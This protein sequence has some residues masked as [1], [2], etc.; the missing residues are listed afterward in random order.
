MVVHSVL[1]LVYLGL[2]DVK[3]FVIGAAS[4]LLP[5]VPG[6]EREQMAESANVG[7]PGKNEAGTDEGRQAVETGMDEVAQP[8]A[9]EDERAGR[10][11]HLAC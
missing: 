10:N 4:G 11:S 2:K 1:C 8:N 6:E 7:D 5:P 3:Q 9:N